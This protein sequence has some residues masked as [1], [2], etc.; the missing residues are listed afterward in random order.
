MTFS[1]DVT[2]NPM[3]SELLDITLEA[4]CWSKFIS[5]KRKLSLY[6]VNCFCINLW[7]ENKNPFTTFPNYAQCLY[8]SD[9]DGDWVSAT[10][11]CS[12]MTT[13]SAMSFAKTEEKYEYL[14]SKLLN[15]N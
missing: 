2:Y 13:G 10:M 1:N 3:K 14:L 7:N 12:S 15:K 11:G 5:I 9:I 4:L 8:M 6:L